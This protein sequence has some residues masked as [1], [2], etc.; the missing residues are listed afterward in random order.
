MLGRSTR[1]FYSSCTLLH[2]FWLITL[3]AR[4]RSQVHRN[5]YTWW[6]SFSVCDSWARCVFNDM[7]RGN[8]FCRSFLHQSSFGGK[9]ETN[10]SSSLSLWV[11]VHPHRLQFVL[12]FPSSCMSFHPTCLPRWFSGFCTRYIIKSLTHILNSSH[13]WIRSN[14]LWC[15]CIL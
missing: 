10:E 11:S 8:Y 12:T 1:H 13:S 3:L 9:W 4:G 6:I 14:P 15:V 2:I 7:R 5:S